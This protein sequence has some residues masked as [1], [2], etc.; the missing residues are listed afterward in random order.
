MKSAGDWLA[1]DGRMGEKGKAGARTYSNAVYGEEL[2]VR[3]ELRGFDTAV[4]S[5][6][7]L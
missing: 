1:W 4:R 7:M 6:W 5:K 2:R 3:E